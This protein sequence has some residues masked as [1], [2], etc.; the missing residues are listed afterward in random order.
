MAHDMHAGHHAALHA[1]GDM[2]GM[3]GCL[4]TGIMTVIQVMF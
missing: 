1:T 4:Q 3:I 2:D